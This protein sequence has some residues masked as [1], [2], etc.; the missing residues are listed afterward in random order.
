MD[1]QLQLAP[2]DRN[3]DPVEQTL[4]QAQSAVPDAW[5]LQLAQAQLLLA[6]DGIAAVEP[7]MQLL[8]TAEQGHAEVLPLWLNLVFLYENLGRSADAD[9]ALQRVETLTKEPLQATAWRVV[10]LGMRGQF[11]EAEAMLVEGA[12]Q[13]SDSSSLWLPRARLLLAYQKGI[14][15][16]VHEALLALLAK[17]PDSTQWLSQLAELALSQGNGVEADRWISR[18]KE[19]EQPPVVLWKFFQVR[20]LALRIR[21]AE[22]PDVER[23]RE[24][25][26][27]IRQSQPDWR[28]LAWMDGLLAEIE[29]RPDA[30]IES[31]A[32]AIRGGFRQ[33]ELWQQL[34]RLLHRQGRFA[35]AEQWLRRFQRPDSLE[36]VAEKT[37]WNR[38]PQPQRLGWAIERAQEEIAFKPFD[39]ASRVWLARLLLLDGRRSEATNV[40]QRAR[41]LDPQDA[42]TL[43]SLLGCCLQIG[44]DAAARPLL[45]RLAS[46]PDLK[47][48]ERHLL[49]GPSSSIA[50]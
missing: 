27:E 48:A 42:S 31:F 19:I 10:L 16:N 28:G 32:H 3:W 2:T 1:R 4:D 26:D 9:R 15:S 17:Q 30:A 36:Q 38:S 34:V 21:S 49:A 22:S 18:L 35:E 8:R 33:E 43:I 46:H 24:L 29:G 7:V 25:I 13:D 6:R 39:A 23:M 5:E 44:E 20:R 12:D 37:A 41:E 45:E 47:G 14:S 40:L 11:E 50:G